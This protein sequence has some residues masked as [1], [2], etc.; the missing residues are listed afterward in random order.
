MRGG[1]DLCNI[2][3]LAELVHTAAISVDYNGV[4]IQNV[5]S[6]ITRTTTERQISVH[7]VMVMVLVQADDVVRDVTRGYCQRRPTNANLI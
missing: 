6:E 2:D 1:D 3:V 4:P 7:V 5:D